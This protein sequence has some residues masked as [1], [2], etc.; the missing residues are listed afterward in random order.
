VVKYFITGCNSIGIS[1]NKYTNGILVI[2]G[3]ASIGIL[4]ALKAHLYNPMVLSMEF[5]HGNILLLKI[6]LFYI[7]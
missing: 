1:F 5:Y 4:F 6:L 2:I 3:Y 7:V